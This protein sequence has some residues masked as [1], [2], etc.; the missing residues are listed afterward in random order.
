MN[1]RNLSLT[2]IVS[3]TALSFATAPGAQQGN[4]ANGSAPTEPAS[5]ESTGLATQLRRQLDEKGWRASTAEDGSVYYLPPAPAATKPLPVRK[6]TLADQLRTQLEQRGW[7]ANSA[8]DGSTYYLPPTP[9]VIQPT[10]PV[11]KPSLAQQLSSELENKGWIAT[12]AEDGSV[13]YLPPSVQ[14]KQ[15]APS[16]GQ[17]GTAA[18]RLHKQLKSLGWSAAPA[19]DG[20]VYYRAPATGASTPSAVPPENRTETEQPSSTTDD[21]VDAPDAT[22]NITPVPPVPLTT[23]TAIPWEAEEAQA[24]ETETAS[25]Q[26]AAPQAPAEETTATEESPVTP[27]DKPAGEETP[28][29]TATERVSSPARGYRQPPPYPY[30]WSPYGGP[31]YRPAYPPQP[32]RWQSPY[33]PAP[34]WHSYPR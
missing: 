22:E 11:K 14:K 28:E 29:V 10:A 24:T 27:T 13:Y 7:T 9:G 4:D 20:S 15:L 33:R 21:P 5:V 17:P 32:P 31:G 8:A 23:D 26:P 1:R 25:P 18:T 19:E 16:L 3:V 34:P 30:A 12:R 2:I 6:N